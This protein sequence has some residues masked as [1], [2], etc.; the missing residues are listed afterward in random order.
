MKNIVTFLGLTLSD[1]ASK[2]IVHIYPLSENN[3]SAFNIK[4]KISIFSKN[5][6]LRS[7]MIEGARVNQPDGIPLYKLFPEIYRLDDKY[8]AVKV[9]LICDHKT[10][11][12]SSSEC[13]FEIINKNNTINFKAQK[14]EEELTVHTDFT[15][16]DLSKLLIINFSDQQ[17]KIKSN[18]I[19]TENDLEKEGDD[20]YLLSSIEKISNSDSINEEKVINIETI[21]DTYIA[22]DPLSINI[23]DCDKLQK[24]KILNF[25]NENQFAFYKIN[26]VNNNISGI[27][28]L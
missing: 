19:D 3:R 28:K 15:D 2:T 12:I 11:D 21:E 6:K 9:E 27:N 23:F 17:V 5:L 4:C 7:F 13:N 8:I 22:S 26:E 1:Q 24:N 25:I 20:D 16:F 14:Q 10:V 18:S